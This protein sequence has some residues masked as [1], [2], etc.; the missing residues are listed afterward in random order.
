MGKPIFYAA[1]FLIIACIFISL[2]FI[3]LQAYLLSFLT[4]TPAA[5]TYV[6]KGKMKSEGPS[7]CNQLE[8]CI[9]TNLTESWLC[10]PSRSYSILFIKN[11]YYKQNSEQNALY[12]RWTATYMCLLCNGFLLMFLSIVLCVLLYPPT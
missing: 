12:R 11:S 3:Y 1:H 7:S 5:E 10:V 2:Y 9:G 6:W 4:F 8:C